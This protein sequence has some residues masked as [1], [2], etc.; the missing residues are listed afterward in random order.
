MCVRLWV[1][2]RGLSLSLIVFFL[3]LYFFTGYTDASTGDPLLCAK[4]TDGTYGDSELCENSESNRVKCPVTCSQCPP[5][6]DLGVR[7]A[8]L[9]VVW[10]EYIDV[11]WGCAVPAYVLYGLNI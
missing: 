5:V 11:T 8:C 4:L 3:T 6:R 2:S 9:C 7:R 10:V 1:D